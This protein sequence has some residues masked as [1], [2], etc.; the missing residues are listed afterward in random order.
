MTFTWFHTWPKSSR[1]ATSAGYKSPLKIELDSHPPTILLS[2]SMSEMPTG[3]EL[4][5]KVPL[6]PLTL[7]LIAQQVHMLLPS[8]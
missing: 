6:S 7:N 1:V 8:T 3:N 5:W 2:N 4:A